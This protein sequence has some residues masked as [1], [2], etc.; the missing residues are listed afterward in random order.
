MNRPLP[1]APIAGVPDQLIQTLNNRFRMIQQTAGTPAAGGSSGP[2]PAPGTYTKVT[3]NGDGVVT[4]GT[5]LSLTDLPGGGYPVSSVCGK[6]G[7]VLLGPGD[8]GPLAIVA[9]DNTGVSANVAAFDLRTGSGPLAAGLYRVSVYLTM[10]PTGSA[11]LTSTVA[12]TDSRGLAVAWT[13]GVGP[14][15]APASNGVVL[16][17]ELDGT[18]D[19]T[20]AVAKTGTVT[21][22]YR[23]AVERVA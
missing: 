17:V 5:T 10:T 1:I 4:A 19:L 7:T 2:T 9:V 16:A 11:S 6:T 23:V 3:V 21:Y 12:F 14:G 18:H 13:L 20:F 8:I 15:S 22:N